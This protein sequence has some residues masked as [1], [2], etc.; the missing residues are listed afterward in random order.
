MPLLLYRLL[1]SELHFNHSDYGIF[2]QS[3]IYQRKRKKILNLFHLLKNMDLCCYLKWLQCFL[4]NS[5]LPTLL[6]LLPL[7]S[8]FSPSPSIFSTSPNFKACSQIYLL[9]YW[10]LNTCYRSNENY[11]GPF[12][13]QN[14]SHW[15]IIVLLTKK[16]GRIYDLFPDDLKLDGSL[17]DILAMK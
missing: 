9:S 7:S 8:T 3:Y 17:S 12:L 1:I 13:P 16:T 2:L 11:P 5:K 15:H 6:V 14:P 4:S 10:F